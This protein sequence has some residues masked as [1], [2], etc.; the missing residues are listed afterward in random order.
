MWLGAL[1]II[2]LLAIGARSF[3]KRRLALP[4]DERE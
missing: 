3:T 2:G 4:V 1:G